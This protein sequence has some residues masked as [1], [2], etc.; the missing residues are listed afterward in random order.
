MNKVLLL[1]LFTAL[2]SQKIYHEP[3]KS[4]NYGNSIEIDIFTDLQGSK[5]SSYTLFYKKDNQTS[6]FREELKT[7][8]E[9]YYSAII[10]QTFINTDDI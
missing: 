10:P 7:E 8:D 5:I 2:F 6:Y 4:I 9:I 3:I 1:L